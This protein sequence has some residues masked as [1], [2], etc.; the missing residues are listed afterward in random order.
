MKLLKGSIKR[1]KEWTP[2][3]KFGIVVGDSKEEFFIMRLIKKR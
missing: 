1:G 2:K 3:F